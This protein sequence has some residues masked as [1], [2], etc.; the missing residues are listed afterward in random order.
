VRARVER[1]FAA[2]L[3]QLALAGAIGWTSVTAF[4]FI[5]DPTT[6]RST[7]VRSADETTF[8][9]IPLSLTLFYHLTAVADRTSIPIVPYLGAGLTWDLWW[10][11]R[12]DGEISTAGNDRARGATLGWE[13]VAGLAVRLDGL[14]RDAA[15]TLEREIGVRHVNLYFEVDA[16]VV[17]GLGQ[18]NRL[19]VGDTTWT[20]GL[21]FDL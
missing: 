12:A 21:R 13:G 3:G 4:A 2:P 20:A 6:G 16:A 19:H 18:T 8:H 1:R 9:L 11:T 15:R 10:F 7:G 5:E 14:D 17:N